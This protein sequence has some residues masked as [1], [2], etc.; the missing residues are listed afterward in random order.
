[1]LY[2]AGQLEPKLEEGWATKSALNELMASPTK[3]LLTREKGKLA[4]KSICQLKHLDKHKNDGS[5]HKEWAMK[6]CTLEENDKIYFLENFKTST[7]SVNTYY[8]L[9]R[10][11]KPFESVSIETRYSKELGKSVPIVERLH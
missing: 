2:V 4:A 11:G 1:M 3:V 10:N 5:S 7:G 8:L 9:L 6:F